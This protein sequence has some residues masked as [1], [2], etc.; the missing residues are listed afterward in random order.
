MI[1]S[2][3]D[4]SLDL[5]LE[6]EF[7]E[8]FNSAVAIVKDRD[9]WLLGLAKRTGDD[10]SFKW[11]HPG[12]GIKRG[13]SAK[14]AAERECYEETGIRCRA[15][16]EPFTSPKHKG[17]AFV[18]CKVTS[19]GQDPEP[20]HEFS[21]LGFFTVRELKSLKLYDNVRDLIDRAKRMM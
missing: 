3:F 20:N 1:T 11:C 13:E 12:G 5:I 4:R 15:K 17:V 10:R 18:P 16:G 19:S 21:A 14:K 9:R 6:E 2:A 7:K 8:D